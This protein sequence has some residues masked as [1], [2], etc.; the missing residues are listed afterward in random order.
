MDITT[1]KALRRD[2]EALLR[3]YDNVVAV[4]PAG[5]NMTVRLKGAGERSIIIQ[6]TEVLHEKI[7][8]KAYASSRHP[9]RRAHVVPRSLP[10][11]GDT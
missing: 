2:I 7:A 10:E 6:I 11:P 8:A 1:T 3:T 4:W 9:S 5:P